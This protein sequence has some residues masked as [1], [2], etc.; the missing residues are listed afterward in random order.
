MLVR[1]VRRHLAVAASLAIAA[2][3]ALPSVAGAA[4]YNKTYGF[5]GPAGLYAYGM[6]FDPTDNTVLVGDYWNY[7]VKRYSATGAFQRIVSHARPGGSLGGI[8]APYDVETDLRDRNSAN[9]ASYWVADQG[10]SRIVQFTHNGGWLQTIG[11]GGGGSDAS[12]PGQKYAVGCGGGKMTIPTHMWVSPTTGRLYVSDP[13]CRAVYVFGHGGKYVSSFNWSGSG[14]GTPIPRGIAGDGNG[15]IYVVEHAT[16]SIYVFNADGKF[17]RKF[18]RVDDMNDPRGLDVDP[19]SQRVYVVSAIKNKVYQFSTGGTFIRSWGTTGGAGGGGQPFDSIRF[20]AVD[21]KGNVYLGD[22]WGYRVWKFNQNGQPLG[23]SEGAQPPPNGGYNR[24]NGVG[25]SPAGDLFVVDTFEQRVQKFNTASSCP[26]KDQCP[27]WML[28]FGSREPAGLNSRGFGYPRELI[29]ADGDVWIGDNNNAVLI[30]SAGGSFIH[31]FGTQGTAP[32]QFKGGVQGLAVAGGKVYTTD[33]GNCRLQVF[34]K[35]KLMAAKSIE[36]APAGTL[37]GHFGTCGS[38]ANEMIGPRGIAVDGTHV[39][40]GEAGGRIS[41]WNTSTGAHRTYK[42][43]CGSATLGVTLDLEWNN[44]HT[45]IYAADLGHKRVVRF[46]PSMTV[47]EGV[48]AGGGVPGGKW[49]GP[50]YLAFGP[51]GRLYVSDNSRHVYAFTNA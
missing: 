43:K 30:W 48:T 29:F 34:D 23:W 5:N 22:T 18:A 40:V 51:D 11:L 25:V 49:D 4:T 35:A 45:W 9:E 2:L 44:A 19:R 50:H 17:L 42:P 21:N 47:C 33:I 46:N 39:F 15:H 13:R 1:G 32:G 24:N 37:L 16:R 27:A 10:S 7:R 26:N 41:I 28:K 20:P 6:D 38:G 36:T 12:H 14:A 31:R 8:T 3:A